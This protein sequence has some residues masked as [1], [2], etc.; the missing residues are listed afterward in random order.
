MLITAVA[1]A[2]IFAIIVLGHG[3]RRGGI[4]SFDFWNQNDK[5]VYWVLMPALLFQNMSTTAFDADLVGDYAIVILGS[6]AA[7]VAFGLGASRLAGYAGP[8]TSSIL[9]GSARHNTFITLAVAERLYGGEGLALAALA[10]AMLILA[11]VSKARGMQVAAAILKDLARNPLLLAVAI[12]P[13]T[14]AT[15]A[16]LLIFP[17]AVALLARLVGLTEAQTMVAVIFGAAPTASSAYTLARQLGGDAPLMAAI[18]TL[19]TAIA[20]LSLPATLWLL[21]TDV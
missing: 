1:I 13:T 20:F 17:A 2:P 3:L 16:K 19:Q 18:V 6:F 21:Q 8:V 5:L 14:L 12:G 7:A 4:P 11:L 15:L 9:Q 10:A